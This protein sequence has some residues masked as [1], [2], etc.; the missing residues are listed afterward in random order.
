MKNKFA[1]CALALLLLVPLVLT[2]C[3][4]EHQF[5]VTRE[6]RP[7]CTEE[8]LTE[9]E[10]RFCG[11]IF[12]EASKPIGHRYAV[13]DEKE[14]TCSQTGYKD[15]KCTL[16]EDRYTETMDALGHIYSPGDCA[17]PQTCSRCGES[18]AWGHIGEGNYCDRCGACTY[19]TRT[20]KGTG[21]GTVEPVDL[22]VGSYRIT[23]TYTGTGSASVYFNN[24]QIG[25]AYPNADMVFEIH[26]SPTDRYT[27][28][29][30]TP[31]SGGRIELK[32]VDGDWTLMIEAIKG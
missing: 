24:V 2:S 18:V 5:A 20:Y 10:C 1:V 30:G 19:E 7:T 4:H 16:C 11:Q 12:S 28:E 8:G 27:T 25:T 23:A 22:P 29:L 6:E 13:V 17:V 15:H 31:L 32:V 9:Y 26:P 14:P 3:E 21:A